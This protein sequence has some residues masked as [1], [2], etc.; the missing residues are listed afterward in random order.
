MNTRE[1]EL[2]EHHL[3]VCIKQLS[4]ALLVAKKSCS[5]DEFLEIKDMI[6]DL[7]ARVDTL[8]KKKSASSAAKLI[9]D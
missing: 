9:D 3:N 5:A 4:L 1:A 8:C 6:G 7:I 2:F